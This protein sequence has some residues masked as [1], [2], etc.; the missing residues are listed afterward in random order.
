MWYKE[1]AWRI[2]HKE[3]HRRKPKSSNEDSNDEDDDSGTKELDVDDWETWMQS[4]VEEIASDDEV[5]LNLDDWNADQ[6][7]DCD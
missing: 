4:D 5:L 1:K 7:E 2:E 6:D 3:K